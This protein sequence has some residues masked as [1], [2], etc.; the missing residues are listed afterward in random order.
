MAKW[1]IKYASHGSK[2]WQIV[3]FEGARGSE[4]SG[5]VDLIAM[6]RDYKKTSRLNIKKGD[7]FEILLIQAKGGNAADPTPE[8]IER[9]KS[10]QK[11]YKARDVVLAK[12]K[13]GKYLKFCVLERSKWKEKEPK[14]IFR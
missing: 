2:D 6:R 3:S 14:E 8:D 10:V 4:S 5:V 12:W 13:K 11:Y 9:L 1:I 7:L